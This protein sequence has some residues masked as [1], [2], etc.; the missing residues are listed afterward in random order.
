MDR[1]SPI[2]D[3][4]KNMVDLSDD[5]APVKGLRAMFNIMAAISVSIPILLLGV[6]WPL[7]LD[8]DSLLPWLVLLAGVLSIPLGYIFLRSLRRSF[9]DVEGCEVKGFAMPFDDAWMAICGSLDEQEVP[10]ER[11]DVDPFWNESSHCV[12]RFDLSGPD[13]AVRTYATD[14]GTLVIL[15]PTRDDARETGER[16]KGLVE[17]ALAPPH[18]HD[19]IE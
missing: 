2:S 3:H 18:H 19:G 6:L 15:G 11:T 9:K 7:T 8:K 1:W 4:F 14:Y 17:R 13:L 12:M 10:Y 5:W 16:L